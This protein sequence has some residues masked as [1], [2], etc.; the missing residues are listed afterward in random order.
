MSSLPSA[1]CAAALAAGA[2]YLHTHPVAPQSPVDTLTLAPGYAYYWA[3][4]AEWFADQNRLPEAR[5]SFQRAF[6][7]A[8]DIPQIWLRQANFHFA[9]EEPE[10]ALPLAARVLQTVSD[11][12]AILFSYFDRFSL[13]PSRVLSAIG[14]RPRPVQAYFEY[15]LGANAL[16]A[17]G[18]VWSFLRNRQWTTSS[19]AVA[20][21]ETLLRHRQPE[22]AAR[23]WADWLGA[24]GADYPTRNL[25]YNGSFENPL[26]GAPLDWRISAYPSVEALIDDINPREG[27]HSLRITFSG[28][29]NVSY[30]HVAQVVPVSPGRL[31][32]TAW[33][34]SQALTTDEGPRLEVAD[35][36]NPHVV[37]ASS[38]PITGS[39]SWTSLRLPVSV[40]PF[41]R[42]VSVRVARRPS[43]RFDS[44]I[45]GTLWLDCVTLTASRTRPGGL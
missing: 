18:E 4:L 34:R 2:W 1:L 40:P 9:L 44:K 8:R 11:Y 20:Y 41:T 23:V 35:G 22:T 19:L 13:A 27:A 39:H 17:A 37:L 45:G 36:E 12:D 16:G 26:S 5:A 14:S 33:Y 32:L 31:T 3:D 15:L 29:D 43:Y 10:A 28:T 24:R 6:A 25:L 30:A 38:E 21:L 7:L 42:L